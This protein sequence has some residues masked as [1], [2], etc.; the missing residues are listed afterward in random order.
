L[1]ADALAC[2]LAGNDY[3]QWR[4]QLWDTEAFPPRLPKLRAN[5]P[6]IV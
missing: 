5:Y 2:S 4:R 6:S 1:R 3:N